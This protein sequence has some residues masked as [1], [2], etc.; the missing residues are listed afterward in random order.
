ML[1]Y[2]YAT[3]WITSENVFQLAFAITHGDRKWDDLHL[4][5]HSIPGRYIHTLDLSNLYDSYYLPHTTSFARAL[6]DIFLLV[7]NLKHLK[8]PHQRIPIDADRLRYAPFNRG[9][10]A[11]EGLQLGAIHPDERNRDPLVQLLREYPSLEVLTLYG[12]GNDDELSGRPLHE[13]FPFQ[14]DKLH[15]LGL[16]QVKSGTILNTLIHSDLPSIRRLKLT[17]YYNHP[18]DRTYALQQAHGHKILS[19]TYIAAN[20]WPVVHSLPPLDT[21]RIHPNLIHFSFL[22]SNSLHHL[23]DMLTWNI[24]R[25]ANLPLRSLTISRWNAAGTVSPNPGVTQPYVSAIFSRIL[26]DRPAN[27]V[28]I[29]IDGFRWVRAGLGLKASATGDSGETLLWSDRFRNVGMQLWDMDGHIA[30]EVIGNSRD[31]RKGRRRISCNAEQITYL[32][33]ESEEDGA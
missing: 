9:L 18:H 12:L 17:S 13:E 5:P 7:P 29:S 4:H 33:E 16:T 28:V 26:R 22:L 32:P 6:Y 14:L 25:N 27:L 2:L 3:P 31:Q 1:K 10:K 19:L 23:L 21:L 11:L 15:T 30:P 20:E 8:F 24:S